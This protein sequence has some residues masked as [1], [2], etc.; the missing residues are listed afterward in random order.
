[1]VS[2]PLPLES[3]NCTCND[4][5]VLSQLVSPSVGVT[6]MIS[7]LNPESTKSVL[8]ASKRFANTVLIVV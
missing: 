1:L 3:N 4:P 5:A 2:V 6:L 8:T 7:N